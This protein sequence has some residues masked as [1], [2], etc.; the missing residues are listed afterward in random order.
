MIIQLESTSAESVE[1]ARSRL[2]ALA[3]SWG[4]E[5]SQ[6]SG[7]PAA[8]A[9]RH[10]DGKVIDPVALASLVLSLPSAALAVADLADR[11]RKRHRAKD[12]IDQAQQ[13]AVQQVNI[14]VMAKGQSVELRTLTPDQL[15]DQLAGEETAG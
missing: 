14:Y 2:E 3:R 9:D 7:N 11:I 10:D 13:L 15:I 8:R 1:A 12:L 5:I 4:Q 6:A